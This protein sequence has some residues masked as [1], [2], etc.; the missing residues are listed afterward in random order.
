MK[1]LLN[2][3]TAILLL[4]N[5]LSLSA[6]HSTYR[7]IKIYGDGNQLEIL[8]KRGVCLDHGE[9]KPGFFFISDF[10]ENE[11]DIIKKSGLKFEVMIDDVSAFYRSQNNTTVMSKVAFVN[12]LANNVSPVYPIPAHF[13]Q[14]SMGGFYTLS[15][16]YAELDSM[17]IL[18]PNLI[19][20]RQ[21]VSADTTFEGRQLFFVKISD[22]PNLNEPEPQV[23]YSALHHAREPLGMQQLIYYMWYLLENYTT[24]SEA[25]YIVDNTEL[26]FIPCVNPDGYFYNETTDPAGGG[27]WRKNRRDNLDGTFGVDLNRNYSVSWGYDD[28]GSSPNSSSDV[29][30]GSAPASEPEI[31]MINN[32]ANA[33]Q[34]KTALDFHTYGNLLIYPWGYIPDF[35]CPDSNIF[36]SLAINYT[37]YNKY[38]YGTPNQTVNYAVN[39][40][41]VDWMYG[42]QTSKPK[43]FDFTP[44]CGYSFW[45]AQSDIIDIIQGAIYMDV[46]SAL[47]AGP[48]AVVKDIMPNVISSTNGFIKFN[49]KQLGLDTIATY[50]VTVTPISAAINSTGAAKIYTNPALSQSFDDSIS[51]SLNGLPPNGTEL[52]YLLTITNG[53]FIKSDT[54]TKTFGFPSAL[55]A[56]DC[57][58]L[59]NFSSSTQWAT[60]TTYYNSPA[61]S[62][63]DSP[64]GNYASFTNNNLTLINTVSLIGS[65]HAS[66]NFY[67]R[68]EIESNYDY[69]QVLVSTDNG[70]TW[71][72][73]CGKYTHPGSQFQDLGNPIYDGQQNNWVKEEMSLDDYLGMN[74]KIRF[75]MV[76]DGGTELD[77]FYFDDL[78][79]EK[80]TNNV[81]V[82]LNQQLLSIGEPVPNPAHDYTYI[83]YNYSKSKSDITLSIYN[84]TGQKISQY[85]LK[86]NQDNFQ[87]ITSNFESGIY[88]YR[89]ENNSDKSL[90][91]KLVIIK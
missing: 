1:K 25:Q 40:G 22:N 81:G 69:A 64:F 73:L 13:E 7:K 37:Q 28:T 24:N 19:T 16:M 33:H 27:L 54:I 85:Q 71:I 12:C 63:T 23:Y 34:F 84:L 42:E 20:T 2:F 67:T 51:Y 29:Y 5:F 65:L 48:Y 6:Q 35:E 44:E 57:S 55:L 89:I 91:K 31:Q 36:R 39:G 87:L 56:D 26:Y 18:Y 86:A 68:W 60:T 30:R 45:P 74:I 52:K 66:L 8:A 78:T 21:P 82:E 43:I 10:N 80:M 3:L 53:S 61:T 4:F 11:F 79:I 41:S 77:G 14:G 59:N 72:P 90:L 47:V 38:R 76:A 49:F 32:F 50:T 17:A 75:V 58:N 9:R 70:I 62:I 88:L 83:N 46:M 15:E